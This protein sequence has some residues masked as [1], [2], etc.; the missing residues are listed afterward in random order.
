MLSNMSIR[1]VCQQVPDEPT[2]TQ[3]QPPSSIQASPP[4]QDNEH[5]QEEEDQIQDNEPPQD[6]GI[7]QG[8]D[9]VEQEKKDEQEIQAQRLPHLRVHQAIQ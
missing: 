1:D 2:P 7:D 3:D 6:N 8:G 5:A 9:E 4:T